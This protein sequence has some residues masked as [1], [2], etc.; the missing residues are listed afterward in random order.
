[1]YHGSQPLFMMKQPYHFRLLTTF[2][3]SLFAEDFQNF[4]FFVVFLHCVLK[5]LLH[6]IKT[7]ENVNA[8]C[9]NVEC[10]NMMAK[11]EKVLAVELVVITK[12]QDKTRWQCMKKHWQQSLNWSAH[13]NGVFV[14]AGSCWPSESSFA[15][16]LQFNC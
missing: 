15:S 10:E 2:G 9:S 1:M 11:H 6:N 4:L 14:G 3:S 12:R 16:V 7:W 5:T 13:P 8:R